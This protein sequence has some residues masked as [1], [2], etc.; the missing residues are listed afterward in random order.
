MAEVKINIR[1]ISNT[2]ES[3]YGYIF[4][5]LGCKGSHTFVTDHTAKTHWSFNGDTENPHFNPSLAFWVDWTK[6][7][8]GYKCHLFLHNGRIQYLNDCK[9]DLAGHTIDIPE[10]PYAK[11][12]FGGID[13][14]EV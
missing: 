9:H 11:G 3:I 2:D 13:E 7:E 14:V 10:W 8:L 4:W 12:N 6:Q 5:C 1:Q